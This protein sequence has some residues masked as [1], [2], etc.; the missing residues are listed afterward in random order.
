MSP[1]VLSMRI[2]RNYIGESNTLREE[3]TWEDQPPERRIRDRGAFCFW[4]AGQSGIPT[5]GSLG[6]LASRAYATLQSSAESRLRIGVERTVKGVEVRRARLHLAPVRE[7]GLVE[8]LRRAPGKVV[9]RGSRPS[10]GPGSASKQTP[11]HKDQSARKN[12]T[13]PSSAVGA[14]QTRAN[15]AQAKNFSE[16][17]GGKHRKP[18][19]ELAGEGSLPGKCYLRL[20]WPRSG[21]LDEDQLRLGLGPGLLRRGALLLESLAIGYSPGQREG[22]EFLSPGSVLDCA[23]FRPRESTTIWSSQPERRALRRRSASTTPPCGQSLSPQDKQLNAGRHKADKDEAV[24]E[25]M[26]ERRNVRVAVSRCS[27]EEYRLK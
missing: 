27:K 4:F 16:Q 2:G 26:P 25:A 1:C 20:R 9:D 3:D 15:N 22:P 14:Q 12:N 6:S 18:W 21:V 5:Q 17:T 8:V 10:D 24:D 7:Q 19:K 13:E 11:K 23:E